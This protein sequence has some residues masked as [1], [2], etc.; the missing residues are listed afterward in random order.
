MI[1]VHLIPLADLGEH[2]TM[3]TSCKCDYTTTVVENNLV[4]THG[5]WDLRELIE[6][7]N[8]ILGNNNETPGWDTVTREVTF[9]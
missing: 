3:G 4:V 7:A 8:V 5:A 2:D 6:E 9:R 1:I